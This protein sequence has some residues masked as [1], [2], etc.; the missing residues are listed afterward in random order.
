MGMMTWNGL[1]IPARSQYVCFDDRPEN[2]ER[3]GIWGDRWRS[4]MQL[5]SKHDEHGR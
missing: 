4:E 1:G 2:R 5:G 3:L